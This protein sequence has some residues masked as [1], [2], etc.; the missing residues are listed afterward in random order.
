MGGVYL[1]R[2]AFFQ[3]GFFFPFFSFWLTYLII[4]N[5]QTAFQNGHL[6][7]HSLHDGGDSVSPILASPGLCCSL[8]C[9]PLTQSGIQATD[10]FVTLIYLGMLGVGDRT[11]A[12]QAGALPQNYHTH[13]LLMCF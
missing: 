11:H 3:K 2:F 7:L 8:K 4:R 13:S 12:R 9:Q 10:L 5:C 1:L 6:I